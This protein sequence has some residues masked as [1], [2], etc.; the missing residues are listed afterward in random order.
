MTNASKLRVDLRFFAD[1][2]TVGVFT[3][4][5]AMTTLSNQ[6]IFLIKNDMREHNNLS[7]LI[8]FCRHCGDDYAGLLSTK[9]RCVA[10]LRQKNDGPV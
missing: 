10:S 1:L 7:I 8:S 6:L 2:V 4:K 5:E 3:E 9:Y